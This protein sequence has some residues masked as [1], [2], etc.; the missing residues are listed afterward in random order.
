[1]KLLIVAT[2]R[3]IRA[4]LIRQA[5]L[6][7]HQVTALEP[8]RRWFRWKDR[9][10]RF[11]VGDVLHPK[12]LIPAVA[13]QQAVICWL[14]TRSARKPTTFLSE[15]TGNLL[16]AMYQCGAHSLIC[17]SAFGVG[18]SRGHGGFFHD[19]IVQR[20]LQ[21]G[22][23]EDRE[24]QEQLIRY[25]DLDWII[26]RPAKV[27]RGEL[28]G[29]YM[30]LTDLRNVRAGKISLADVVHFAVA[31]LGSNFYVHKAPLVTY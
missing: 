12:S 7:G 6:A 2:S 31:Q 24:R 26:V 10:V 4:E 15:G 18:N 1:M 5:K 13:G 8:K 20:V 11:A 21:K 17:V 30:S 9:D 14:S 27:V 23:Y 25:T 16:R 29:Q 22:M 28:T 3:V 19:A